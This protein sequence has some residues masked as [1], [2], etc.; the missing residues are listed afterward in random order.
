MPEIDIK[1]L[2]QIITD[3]IAMTNSKD[4][5]SCGMRNGMRWCKALLEDDPPKFE[6]AQPA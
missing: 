3:G 5:Y 2:K 4:A 1:E 6:D